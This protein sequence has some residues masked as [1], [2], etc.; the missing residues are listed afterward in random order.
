MKTQNRFPAALLAAALCA[1]CFSLGG[2]AANAADIEVKMSDNSSEGPMA[3]TPSFIKA[4]V[5]D[6]LVFTP[7]NKGHDT[8]SLLVPAGAAAWKGPFDKPF[9]VKLEKEGVYLFACDSHK[10]MG[11]VGVAQVG[12][13]T[14]LDAAK[15]KATEES[16]A[17]FL[18]KERF[19]KAL[20]Q[21]H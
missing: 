20:D 10:S 8:A 3:F 13:P 19:S 14:N 2:G 12:K 5:G 16:A 9:R 7:L 21:V 4:N 15:R 1:G 11:M 18:N 17:I 6:V